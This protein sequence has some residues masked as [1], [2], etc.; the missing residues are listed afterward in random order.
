MVCGVGFTTIRWLSNVWV[1]V[2]SGRRICDRV[3]A[4]PTEAGPGGESSK[5]AGGV[6]KDA[7]DESASAATMRPDH[8]AAAFR[9]ISILDAFTDGKP[10]LARFPRVS[11]W[12]SA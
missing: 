7:Q 12:R 5:V 9:A 8:L 1:A 6:F 4:D 3:E 2:G 11:K 10:K